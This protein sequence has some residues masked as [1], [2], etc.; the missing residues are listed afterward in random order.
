MHDCNNCT[1]AEAPEKTYRH[2]LEMRQDIFNIPQTPEYEVYHNDIQELEFDVLCTLTEAIQEAVE[3]TLEMESVTLPCH[4]SV[5]VSTYDKM[6]KLNLE[7][8]GVDKSTD[9]LS[10]PNHEFQAGVAP[11]DPSLLEPDNQRLFLG[12]VVLCL[13]HCIIQGREHGHST[14]QEA[15]YLTVH[16]ILHLL[17]YDHL[18]EAEAKEV[19]RQR[20]K[21]ILSQEALKPYQGEIL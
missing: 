14:I 2:S 5:T 17:G 11:S 12:D 18:D 1:G 8:R 15:I 7:Q 6:H 3:V 10:F 16:S 9:V 20:E 21:L 4:V 13:N 19:M